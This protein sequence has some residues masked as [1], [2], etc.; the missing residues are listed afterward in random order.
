[1][2]TTDGSFVSCL[3]DKTII[4]KH[5]SLS[6]FEIEIFW[7]INLDYLF[8]N[9]RNIWIMLNISTQKYSDTFR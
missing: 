8:Y 3:D 5:N 4:K 6:K 1:M 2:I 9:T 7:A